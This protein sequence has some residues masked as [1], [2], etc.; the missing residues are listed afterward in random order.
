[1]AFLNWRKLTVEA[2]ATFP[3][4][5]WG[6]RCGRGTDVAMER[7]GVS[8]VEGYLRSINLLSVSLVVMRTFA[9]QLP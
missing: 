9:E 8:L 7:T 5:K 1:M 6:L 2:D 3:C 4:D